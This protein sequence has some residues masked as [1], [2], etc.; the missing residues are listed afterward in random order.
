MAQ[1]FIPLVQTV[2]HVI[3]C[4]F[5]KLAKCKFN[6]DFFGSDGGSNNFFKC[7]EK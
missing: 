6:V 2:D 5:K 1:T 7:C 3:W 4:V